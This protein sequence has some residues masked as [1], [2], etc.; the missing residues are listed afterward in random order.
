LIGAVIFGL[1]AKSV[2]AC[3]LFG[4]ET[5]ALFVSRLIELIRYGA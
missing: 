4:S 3:F 1:I 2:C 5:L